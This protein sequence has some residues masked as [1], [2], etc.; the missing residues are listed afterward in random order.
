M[1][2]QQKVPTEK[3]SVNK[4]VLQKAVMHY[5]AMFL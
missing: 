5:T 2:L 4:G 1:H 3:Y